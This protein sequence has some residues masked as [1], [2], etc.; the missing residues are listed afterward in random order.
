MIYA[1]VSFGNY[2]VSISLDTPYGADCILIFSGRWMNRQWKISIAP[3]LG[4]DGRGLPR[5]S[6]D[7]VWRGSALPIAGLWAGIIPYSNT[8]RMN[9]CRIVVIPL[10]K[11][12]PFQRGKMTSEWFVFNSGFATTRR[13]SSTR[14]LTKSPGGIALPPFQ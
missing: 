3:R 1:R 8:N 12:E 9:S 7:G 4:I 14:G 2:G 10:R 5:I 11:L 6:P 13:A